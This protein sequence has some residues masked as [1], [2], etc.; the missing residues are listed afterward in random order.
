MAL[1]D[2]LSDKNKEIFTNNNEDEYEHGQHPNSLKNLKKWE[3]GES[4]NA[5]GRPFKYQLLKE[6]LQELG[7][8]ITNDFYDK[9]LGSRKLQLLQTIWKKAIKGDIQFVKILIYL[10]VY[11]NE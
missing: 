2:P 6:K 3:K 11:D 7:D 9:P 5:V 10:G 8:E 1:N 4:G